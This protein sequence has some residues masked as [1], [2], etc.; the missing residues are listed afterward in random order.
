MHLAL[1]GSSGLVGQ[2]LSASLREDGHDVSPLVRDDRPRIR[3]SPPSGEI[4]RQQMATVDAV[5]HLAGESIGEGRWTKTKKERIRQSRETATRLLCE[6]LASLEPRPHTLVSASAIGY[7]GDRGSEVLDEGAAPGE[8]FLPEVCVQ[9]EAATQPAR[10]AGIRVV[11]LRIGV[12]LSPD[13]GALAKMLWP[14]KLG[15]GG[16]VGS[17]H[18]Y[19]SWIAL[20]E[21]VRVIRFAVDT[22]ALSGPVN[23]VAPEPATNREFTRVL[24]QVLR[25]PTIFPIPAPAA[26]LALGQMA[27]DLLLA[28][29]RVV[30]KKLGESGY[31]FSWADLEAALRHELGVRPDHSS[32]VER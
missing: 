2:V 29:A 4:D 13:G 17:G 12:V 18:Q 10:E 22:R 7:Y 20:S 6:S 32:A 16:R 30:P 31:D 11:N 21:L 19:W 26:R 1:S 25:R 28:S 27:N 24:G 5:V 14:F 3:W 9:W 15:L 23:A 8:G